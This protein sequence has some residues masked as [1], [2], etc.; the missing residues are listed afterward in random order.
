M[1]SMTLRDL[2]IFLQ[3]LYYLLQSSA[4]LY[5]NAQFIDTFYTTE[6]TIDRTIRM[7][8][9]WLIDVIEFNEV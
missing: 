4:F 2:S 8:V 6:R 1:R 3:N 7:N 9:E 5:I